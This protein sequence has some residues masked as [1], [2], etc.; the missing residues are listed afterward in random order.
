MPANLE[1][2][3]VAT[4]LEKVS[5]HSNPKERQCQRLLKLPHNFTHLTCYQSNAQNSPSQASTVCEWRT[6]RCS[7]WILKRQRNQRSN[8]QHP[9]D[10]WKSKRVPEK[11]LL[12][13]Y[14][15]CQSLWLCGS[16]QTGK[17]FKRREYQTTLPASWEISMQV[18]KQQLELGIEQ[19]WFQIGKGVCQGCIV[20]MLILLI[21]R[22][23]HVKCRAGRSTS[24]NQDCWEKYQYPQMCR[25][26]HLYG[27]NWK[28]TKEPLDESERRKWKI[29]L[30]T[31]HSE[32]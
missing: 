7:S 24:W 12:L 3:A 31:H 13:L 30:K 8:Y 16:Q 21:C 20:T 10:H 2:S 23:H 6:S 19:D 26:H 17:F 25:W 32:N 11:H 9:L 22:V 15:L 1:N 27:I 18:R 28:G 14:W 5:F 29:W 4:V